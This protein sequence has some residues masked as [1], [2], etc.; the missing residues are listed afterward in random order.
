MD[1]AA[2]GITGM[3]AQSH[4]KPKATDLTRE[5]ATHSIGMTIGYQ[6]VTPL[7]GLAPLKAMGDPERLTPLPTPSNSWSLRPGPCHG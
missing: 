2:V 3:F 4:L 5:S 7:R 6:L 1:E